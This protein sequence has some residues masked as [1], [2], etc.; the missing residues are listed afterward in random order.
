MK[1]NNYMTDEEIQKYADEMQKH[2]YTCK[3]GHRVYIA[4]NKDKA[5]CSWC[6][7]Y[8]FKNKEDE[9]KYRIKEKMNEGIN[10]KRS[11]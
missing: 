1:R 5:L 3:C 2:K 8:C 9:F 11:I 10:N 4:H 6:N 7:E